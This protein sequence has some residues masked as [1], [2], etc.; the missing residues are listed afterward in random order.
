MFLRKV[1]PHAQSA[2]RRYSTN[3]TT[4]DPK[5]IYSVL[6]K[7]QEFE[8][9]DKATKS[10]VHDLFKLANRAPSNSLQ[11][12]LAQFKLNDFQKKSL[13]LVGVTEE[14]IN[15]FLNEDRNLLDSVKEVIKSIV[16]IDNGHIALQEPLEKPEVS[17]S[18][19]KK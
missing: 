19:S 7:L 5:T 4:P 9:A 16:S 2:V 8:K 6:H 1:V 3:T 11:F 13:P 18:H 17:F 15:S 10:I 12:S 14:E